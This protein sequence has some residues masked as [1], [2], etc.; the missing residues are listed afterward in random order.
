[1]MP[2]IR[3]MSKWLGVGTCDPEEAA[4]ESREVQ[5]L[6]LPPGLCGV[7]DVRVKT[8]RTTAG[9]PASFRVREGVLAMDATLLNVSLVEFAR[10]LTGRFDISDVLND[11]AARLPD[12]LAIAGAGVSLV[13]GTELSFATANSERAA[14][15]EKVQEQL[16][17]GPCAEAITSGDD[18]LIRDI[19]DHA[20]RWPEYAAMAE[21][22]G[23]VA[24][25]ALPLRNSI[26]LGALD[27]YHTGV[28]DWT[29]EEVTTARVFADIATGYVLS[30]SE[31]ERER[32]TVEQLE[33]ALESRVIIEQAK[34]ILAHANG[35]NVDAA[36]VRL[37][38]YARAHNANLREVAKAVVSLG[39]R[40]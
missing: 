4:A 22:L 34:G 11:L 2:R 9:G 40:F 19:G 13:S 5:W 29:P 7:L 39:L 6:A 14:T 24:V 35:I 16:N 20:H 18:V 33:L 30:A 27:L 21:R 3:H 37:R 12:V 31:L 32:R 26:R 25:A 23:I 36:F 8:S 17:A 38:T 28:H 1:M 15:L 10:T